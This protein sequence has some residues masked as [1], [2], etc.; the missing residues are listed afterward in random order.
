MVH[1]AG[2]LAGRIDIDHGKQA[3]RPQHVPDSSEGGQGMGLVMNGVKRGDI[4]KPFG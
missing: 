2:L 3:V 4:I 1:V